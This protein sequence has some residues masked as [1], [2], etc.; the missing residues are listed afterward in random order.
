MKQGILHMRY[1]DGR[2]LHRFAKIMFLRVERLIGKIEL[3]LAISRSFQNACDLNLPSALILKMLLTAILSLIRHNC[4]RSG[5]LVE[6]AQWFSDLEF[7]NIHR[8]LNITIYILCL[9]CSILQWHLKYWLL[10]FLAG[11]YFDFHMLF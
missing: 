11:I 4:F 3:S 8:N 7:D 5:F 1:Q 10:C 2:I 6:K 9:I